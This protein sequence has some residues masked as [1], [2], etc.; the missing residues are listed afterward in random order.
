[1][2]NTQ[3]TM[4]PSINKAKR[5]LAKQIESEKR[6]IHGLKIER[7]VIINCKNNFIRDA[8]T[9]LTEI[10]SEEK[11]SKQKINKIMNDYDT[12]KKAFA[13]E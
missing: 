11:T 12:L 13:K 4:N 9:R 8:D 2:S 7:K 10:K 3:L 1:M 6:K 5:D